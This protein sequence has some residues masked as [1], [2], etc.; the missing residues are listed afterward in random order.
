MLGQIEEQLLV[1]MVREAKQAV[2]S[3]RPS[4]PGAE[5]PACGSDGKAESPGNNGIQRAVCVGGGPAVGPHSALPVSGNMASGLD[6]SAGAAA[7]GTGQLEVL[8]GSAGAAATGTGQLEVLPG[9]AGAAAGSKAAGGP[10]QAT[11]AGNPET[12][13]N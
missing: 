2:E 12:C 6:G 9:S 11:P 3:Q 8:P 5:Q 13:P 10:P 4:R 1:Q 7:T